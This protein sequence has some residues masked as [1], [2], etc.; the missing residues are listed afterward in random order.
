MDQGEGTVFS[1]RA[2]S[3][4]W[5]DFAGVDGTAS[6]GGCGKHR[7]RQLWAGG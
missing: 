6:S 2:A 7:A 4:S 3:F 1:L 5:G